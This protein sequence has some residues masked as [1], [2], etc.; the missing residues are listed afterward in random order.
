MLVAVR[1]GAIHLAW[2]LDGNSRRNGDRSSCSRRMQARRAAMEL[3]KRRLPEAARR[4]HSNCSC[5][6]LRELIPHGGDHRS[7]SQ[8][9][10]GVWPGGYSRALAQRAGTHEFQID[11]LTPARWCGTLLSVN[12][13][14]LQFGESATTNEVRP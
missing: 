12:F 5:E 8:R 1:R 13:S 6:L 11:S 2:I 4:Q 7:N 14:F 9:Q 10:C 3:P